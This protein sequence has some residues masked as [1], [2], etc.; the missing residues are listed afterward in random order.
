MRKKKPDIDELVR[1]ATAGRRPDAAR[2]FRPSQ[3]YALL[4]DPFCLWCDYHAPKSGAVDETTRFEKLR[5]GWGSQYETQWVK[6]NHADAVHIDVPWGI[7]ALRATLQAMIDGA[8]AIHGAHLWDL[9]HE[10]YGIADLLVRL[11]DASSDLGPYYEVTEVKRSREARDYHI[12]QA[13][14]YNRALAR[15]QRHSASAVQIALK[16][17][18]RGIDAGG[19]EAELDKALA[20]WK[21][22]RDGR[23][24]PDLPAYDEASSPWRLY[25]NKLLKRRGDLTLCPMFSASARNKLT[26]R[27]GVKRVKD[28]EDHDLADFQ[29]ALGPIAGRHTW[30]RYEA[31]RSGRPVLADG[32]TLSI[33]RGK[34]NLYFDFE[35]AGGEHPTVPPHAY[36]IGVYDLEQAKYVSFVAKGPQ[37]EERMTREFL[38]YVG[39]P[40]DVCLY[41]WTSYE[42]GVLADLS[43]RHPALARPIGRVREACVDLKKCVDKRVFFG[44]RTYSIKEVAPF[45]GFHWRQED[46]DAME[47][48]VLYWEW[49]EDGDETKIAKVICYNED[50]C[51]AMDHVH[52]ALAGLE[53]GGGRT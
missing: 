53:R 27:L 8:P 29:E 19:A 46:V 6:E 23:L 20:L 48:M 4:N 38:A 17:G 37:D 18:V 13:G 34:R 45:L 28:L 31:H 47:S 43:E 14:A 15:I 51:R 11:E 2:M 50:D 24:K 10:T 5:M 21:D 33:P 36:M 49:L 1:R 40:K 12:V 7:L 35:T 16:D 9:G 52:R 30:Y 32:E 44:T 41:H 39:P 25:A 42:L 22:I 26:R 3:A